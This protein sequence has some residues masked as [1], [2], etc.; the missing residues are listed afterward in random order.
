M[1]TPSEREV[2]RAAETF[3]SFDWACRNMR[4]ISGPYKGQLWQPS[5]TPH[6]RWVLDILDMPNIRHFWWMASSQVGKTTGVLAWIFAQLCRRLDSVC[7]GRPDEESARRLFQ[8]QLQAYFKAI[9]A[10]RAL[11]RDGEKSLNTTDIGL[12]GDAK[13]YPAWAGSDSSQRS[14]T[15]PVVYA[16]EQDVYK[17]EDAVDNMNERADSYDRAELSK[18][19][20]TCRPKGDETKS[21][22]WSAAQRGAS[23]WLKITVRCPVCGTYQ[24]MEH[25][26]IVPVDGRRHEP[27]EILSKKLARYQCIDCKAHWTDTARDI[28]ANAGK[29]SIPWSDL[30]AVT[31][32]ALQ[33]RSWESPLVSLSTVLAKWF[34]AQGNPKLMMLWD[35]NEC[36]K[37]YR[38]V[39]LETSEQKLKDSI[40]PM[41]PQG[42]IPEWAL[43]ITFSSDMQKDYF[44]WS[45][46]AHGIGPDRL[47]ILDYGR[48][49][50]WD[51]LKELVFDSR[52]QIGTTGRYMGF[53]RGALDTGGGKTKG[54]DDT[55]P[56]QAYKWLL[57]QRTG[58]I[59]GT[60]GMSRYSPGVFVKDTV[61][62]TLPDGKK[63][64][65][66]YTLKLLDTDS[67]KRLIFWRFGEGNEEEPIT[68]H[69]QTDMN[70][71]KEIASERLVKVRGE[72]KWVA[73]RANHYLDCLVG[74]MAMEQWQW[75]PSLAQLAQAARARDDAA[76]QP[77]PQEN[78]YTGEVE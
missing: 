11:L 23:V 72:E 38:F 26:N 56:M 76:P 74:H 73:H 43:A 4:V 39:E 45:V 34:T 49:Q 2:F 67:F 31:G 8:E 63:L 64:S 40:N 44:K 70:Y 20:Y 24:V 28:A 62:D 58:V 18:R 78:P 35:N 27:Q 14:F 29:P 48:T 61:I 10:L 17:V 36:V 15:A 22:I 46:A 1:F 75:K 32:V 50:T 77:K 3:S 53:W 69:A 54:E 41:L 47:H 6:V 12:K 52:Y 13:L 55:R 25:E 65:S 19:I 37:P 5:V 33:T 59:Y 60:K 30:D 16:D 9:P 71:L 68:F 21:S 51:E 66:P 42:V 7:F 57:A